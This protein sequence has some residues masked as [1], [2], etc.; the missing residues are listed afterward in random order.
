MPVE[1][2][3]YLLVNAKSGK[4]VDVK[5]GGDAS[6]ANVQ[7]WNVNRSDAQIWALTNQG[8]QWQLICSLTGRSLDVAGGAMRNGANVQQWSDNDSGAQRWLIEEDGRTLSVGGVAYPTYVISS[9]KDDS[10]A[11]DVANGSVDAGA[12]IQ[13]YTANGTEAQRWALVPVPC[14][15]EGGTYE[16]VSALDPTLALDVS[17]GST[18]NGAKVQ[19]YKRNGTNAQAWEARVDAETMLVK[20]LSCNSGKAL[21]AN[22]A[23]QGARVHQWAQSDGNQNQLWLLVQSG[24]MKVDGVTVP[25]YVIHAQNANGR[26]LD[27]AGGSNK[28]GTKVQTYT[29]NGSVAQRFALVR[30]EM[31]GDGISAPSS[32]AMVVQGRGEVTADLEFLCGESAYEARYRRDEYDMAHAGYSR[33]PWRSLDEADDA[34]NNG[35]GDAWSPTFTVEDTNGIVE[36]PT[37]ISATLEA[38]SLDLVICEVEIRAFRAAHGQ[39]ASMAHG[40]AT[41]S[42][43]TFTLE[44]ILTVTGASM[45]ADG[46]HVELSCDYPHAGNRYS[47]EIWLDGERIARSKGATGAGSATIA[48]ALSDLGHVPLD[49]DEIEV[50]CEVATADG[51]SSSVRQVVS[52]TWPGGVAQI[53]PV[54]ADE[55]DTL[56]ALVECPGAI[57]GTCLLSVTDAGAPTL[58]ECPEDSRGVWR[59]PYPLGVASSVTILADLGGTLGLASVDLPAVSS[60]AHVWVWG[61]GWAQCCR[62]R[63]N[64]GERPNQSRSHAVDASVSSTTSRRRPVAFA[65]RSIEL[66]LSLDAVTFDDDAPHSSRGDVER[67]LGSLGDGWYPVYRTPRGDWHRVAVTGGETGWSEPIYE[68]ARVRQ[69]AVTP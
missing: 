17:G 35:W 64:V 68:N 25:T 40:P 26:V 8:G 32:S 57:G 31:T 46:L 5:G 1:E 69:Q 23:T 13:I 10:Y 48:F 4:A 19:V 27:V 34:G 39:T 63:A 37:P 15:T 3:T 9:A 14:M 50:R 21:D 58:V 6:G 7:Q 30:T 52:V 43:I 28:P 18:S 51:G 66:D 24:T 59:V 45:R 42:T 22:G 2:G 53:T 41:L 55:E 36:V 33:T 47:A 67:L 65:G 12:N 20:M 44:P 38:G 60:D 49:G 29:A 16:I 56:C 54:V 61:T 11:L 62:L